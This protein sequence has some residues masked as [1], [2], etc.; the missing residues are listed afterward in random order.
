[1]TYPALPPLHESW[2]L[3][4]ANE[5]GLDP[6]GVSAWHLLLS[7]ERAALALPKPAK[8]QDKLI[9]VRLIAW[10]VKDVYEHRMS[11]AYKSLIRQILS[12]NDVSMALGPAQD[13]EQR[14]EKVFRVG[15]DLRNQLFRVF[16]SRTDRTP[17]PS[18][19]ASRPSYGK[20]RADILESMAKV[21]PEEGRTHSQAKADALL[22]D[23]YRCIMTGLYDKVTLMNVP[24]LNKKSDDEGV[25]SV[26]TEVAHLFSGTAQSH[27]DYAASAMAILES[28]GLRSLVN[29]L[30]GKRVHNLFNVMTM[31]VALHKDFDQFL[32]WLEAVPGTEHTYTVVARHPPTFFKQVPKPPREVTFRIDP[33]AA[34]DAAANGIEL[35]L[36]DPELMAIRAACARVA[37]MSGAADQ[38]RLLKEDRDDAGTLTDSDSTIHLLDSLLYAVSDQS[39]MRTVTVGA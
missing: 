30:Q 24:E 2:P 33:D 31:S 12:C 19:H 26:E 17:S 18:P 37:A 23:G 10:L 13:L 8:Y 7:A 11:A 38:L 4:P 32:F 29:K 28:F 6:D 16:C 21:R 9:A 15:I 34:Q 35:F 20:H 39:Y 36:P 14:H 22:R 5:I 27:P 3:P 1:M 25:D